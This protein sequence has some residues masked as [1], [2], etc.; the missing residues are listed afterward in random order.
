MV[1]DFKFTKQRFMLCEGN[2][3]VEFFEVLIAKHN[4][5][6]FQICPVSD[7]SP[8]N[9]GGKDAYK[10][11]LKGFPPIDGW[12]ELKS[13]LLVVDNDDLSSTFT[14]AQTW[15]TNNGYTP[16]PDPTNIGNIDGKPV[17][18]LLVPRYDICGDLEMLVLPSIYEKWGRAKDCVEAFLSCS[19][20]ALWDKKSSVNKA[21]ARS[22]TVGFNKDDPYKGIGKLFKN[23]T[24]SA[25]NP[26]FDEVVRFLENFDRMCG[27]TIGGE[28]RPLLP[29]P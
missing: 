29:N 3:D 17:A 22:A 4:L 23:G 9:S 16:P 19:G 8:D 7:V 12:R 1:N 28:L 5:P 25:M 13:L 20:A 21:R 14:D 6:D 26:C 15:F 10:K 24:L 18:V 11:S 27:I 2:D